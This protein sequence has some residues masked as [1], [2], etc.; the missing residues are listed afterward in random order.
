MGLIGLKPGI[1]SAVIQLEA[2]QENLSLVF[3]D[4]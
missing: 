3:P 2:L 4:F 1:D